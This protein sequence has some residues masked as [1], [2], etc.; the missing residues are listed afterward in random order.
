MRP[1]DVVR[2]S[3]ISVIQRLS[4]YN[5]TIT[6]PNR[7][8][9]MRPTI[10]EAAYESHPSGVASGLHSG[11]IVRMPPKVT[12]EIMSKLP[13]VL[14]PLGTGPTGVTPPNTI[15]YIPIHRIPTI[16]TTYSPISA[17]LPTCPPVELVAVN[18]NPIRTRMER[19]M[20]AR[21]CILSERCVQSVRV[22]GS[23]TKR[24]IQKTAD[25]A[26]MLLDTMEQSNER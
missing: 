9:V 15:R 21:R 2:I 13:V 4:P 5:H 20:N 26:S 22:Q 18:P 3:P 10:L 8:A 24:S 12:A 19:G 6:A 16:P 1:R 25:G 23:P 11:S 14:Q 17:M 7:E